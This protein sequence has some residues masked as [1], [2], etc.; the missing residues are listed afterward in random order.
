MVF[1]IPP[2][3]SVMIPFYVSPLY[4]PF[5]CFSESVFN[6]F[7]VSFSVHIRV[8]IVYHCITVSQPK[9]ELFGSGIDVLISGMS[10]TRWLGSSGSENGHGSNHIDGGI[11]LH[12][13]VDARQG[14][15]ICMFCIIRI[16]CESNLFIR[17]LRCFDFFSSKC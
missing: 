7:F 4:R 8:V 3:L 14:I 15:A 6:P 10:G 9:D 5:Y 2:Q 1:Y 13:P 16:H 11:R 17:G 12:Y